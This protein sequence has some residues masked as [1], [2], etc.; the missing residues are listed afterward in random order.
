[1]MKKEKII[2][3]LDLSLS[4]TGVAIFDMQ[5]ELIEVQSIPTNSRNANH[6]ERLKIIADR[7]IE[8]KNKYNVCEVAFEAGF[9]RH[10]KSTRILSKVAGVA[11]YVF[12]DKKQ[13]FYPP[14][15]VKKAVTGSGRAS[16]EE[17]KEVVEKK[18]PNIALKNLDISDAIS[19]G[20]CHF[21]KVDEKDE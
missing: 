4:N 7:L 11:E 1:M 18:Y 17:L 12:Y 14:S 6:G 8:I 19:V 16:K 21:I 5:R 9:S 13:Y 20:L 3:A 15:T 10:Y 2:L